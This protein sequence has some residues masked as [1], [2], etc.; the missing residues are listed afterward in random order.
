LILESVSDVF[1][2]AG[3]VNILVHWE[4]SVKKIDQNSCEFTNRVISR[5]TEGFLKGLEKQGIPFELFKTQRQGVS[6]YHNQSETPLFAKSIE[7]HAL[8]K[9]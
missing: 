3:Q 5:P 9:N 2:P 6:V 7:Q 8:R 4:L 1:T